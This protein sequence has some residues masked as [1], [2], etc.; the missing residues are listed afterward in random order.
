MTTLSI[1]YPAVTG[2]A[3]VGYR[4]ASPGV[5]GL[6]FVQLELE[7]G[8]SSADRAMEAA[9]LI[10]ADLQDLG[11]QYTLADSYPPLPEPSAEEQLLTLYLER[12]EQARRVL[13]RWAAHNHA[14]IASGAWSRE[15]LYGPTG[16]L[17][18]PH[19]QAAQQL[20]MGTGF[21]AAA[22][23]IRACQHPL[24]TPDVIQAYL[25]AMDAEGALPPA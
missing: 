23:A 18:D 3:W 24:A 2:P 6:V 14:Q 21:G 13:A 22:D 15:D 20:L 8:Q 16:L 10:A 5:E 4:S 7:A 17:S 12:T 25:A 1:A 11:H 19:A 9:I